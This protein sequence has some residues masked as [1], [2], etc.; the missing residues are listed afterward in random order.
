MRDD[1]VTTFKA[2]RIGCHCR[3][4]TQCGARNGCDGC[5]LFYEIGTSNK[6]RLYRM[7]CDEGSL[8]SSLIRVLKWLP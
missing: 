2:D 4:G 3:K 7:V 6:N 1:R 5:K 8:V